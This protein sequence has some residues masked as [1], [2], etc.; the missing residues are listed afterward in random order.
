[1]DESIFNKVY[2]PD[3][4]SCLANLSNDEVFTPPEIVND[5]LDMLPEEL[6]QSPDTTFLDPAC[7]TGVFLREIAKRLIKGLADVIPDL[8]QRIDHIFHKQLFGI[9]IT[10]LTSLLSRRSL[11]CSKYANSRFS[12]THFDSSDGN[13]RFKR[14]EHTFNKDG[15]CAYCGASKREYN[16]SSE[17][18]THAYEF[19]HFVNPEA[20][21]NMKFDVIISNPPYQLSD[22]SGGSTDSAM[23]IY[24]DFIE[25][26]KKLNPRYLTM[27][28]PAKW[29]M[30]GR[31]LQKF[32]ETMISDHRISHMYDY[33][34]SSDCFPGVHIDG[35]ICFFLWQ[36][37]YNG[38][39]QYTYTAADGT[40]NVSNHYLKNQYFEY[41]IRDN[42]IFSIIQKTSDGG[43]FSEIVSNVRPYGIRGY[44]FNEP[45][46][47][48]DSNLSYTP[49]Q[50]C[51]KIYGVKGIKG[52]ARRVEGF[53]S[54]KIV[55]A[56]I[57]TISRYKIFFTTSYSTDAVIPP[58]VILGKPNEICTETFLLVGPFNS[59]Q[60]QLNCA[61]YIKT[62]F[63]RFLLYF[64]KGTMHVTKSVFGLIPKQ[65]FSKSWTD[66]ELYDKY[67]LS[68]DERKFIET[69]IKH[70]K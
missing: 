7:K 3:V 38:T 52:G 29:M 26:A 4:I 10:E 51:L 65:D 60:E 31:G 49:F 1:M 5:M 47:Y 13:I 24:N 28:I 16:R 68:K 64:G 58:D 69:I 42:R 54:H 15:K 43:R 39:T 2:N 36:R 34:L 37:D 62:N 63:F 23:P 22:G 11:Y 6:F 21:F 12:V 57:D 70:R 44:L 50:N 67:N 9:A 25:Q 17:L 18:E 20:I 19:I 61:A 45:E 35:G 14:T 40:V 48:P 66:E 53:I 41:V 59:E 33:E 55:N 46:R 27:V 30:G 32:R 8:Q 56:N